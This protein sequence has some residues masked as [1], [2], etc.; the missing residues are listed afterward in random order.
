MGL[1]LAIDDFGTGYS[2]LAYLRQ[3][4]VQEL[5]IDRSFV[6]FMDKNV[7]DASIVKS[8]IDLAHNLGLIV[9]AEGIESE[10]V[11]NQL[12][13]LGCNEGQGYF[14]GKPM[15]EKDFS[16][17]LERWQGQNE[18]DIDIGDDFTY[19]VNPLDVDPQS[20]DPYTLDNLN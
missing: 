12:A 18:I 4:P 20:Q 11:L 14:I 5:K 17:W 15:P 19:A 3:L 16:I 10:L 1:H 7:G 8:T 6:M 13:K 2:S 9:V